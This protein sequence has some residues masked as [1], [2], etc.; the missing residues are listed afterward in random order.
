M[1]NSLLLWK[2]CICVSRKHIIYIFSLL[3]KSI[4]TVQQ[5]SRSPPI[6]KQFCQSVYTVC[7]SVITWPS[8]RAISLD[9]NLPTKSI[10]A[11]FQ[12]A[13][14]AAKKVI[15]IVRWLGPFVAWSIEGTSFKNSY[16]WLRLFSFSVK[17]LS[18][19]DCSTF[20]EFPFK[21]F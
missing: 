7:I 18:S 20:R 16:L 19:P 12:I 14:F 21:Y 13:N 9:W 2:G 1:P 17:D 8:A 5:F 15:N 10:A 4:S 11:M 6:W 3:S